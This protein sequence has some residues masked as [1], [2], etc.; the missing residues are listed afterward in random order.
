MNTKVEMPLMKFDDVNKNC[1]IY[2]F[3]SFNTDPDSFTTTSIIREI[4]QS[5]QEQQ[6]V[7]FPRMHRYQRMLLDFFYWDSIFDRNTWEM[8]IR[9]E[10]RKFIEENR[11]R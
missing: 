1:R 8:K 5:A 10:Y 11:F 7:L 2:N 3:N 9:D 6:S 4:I